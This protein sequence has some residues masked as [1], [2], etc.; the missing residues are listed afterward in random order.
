[1]LIKIWKKL[2]SYDGTKGTLFS[3]IATITTNTCID[4]LRAFNRRVMIREKTDIDTEGTG[5]VEPDFHI[6][7]ELLWLTDK[8]SSSQKDVVIMIYFRGHTQSEAARLLK[9]PLGTVK[10]RQRSAILALR[11]M[12]ENK[13][14]SSWQIQIT[15]KAK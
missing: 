10:T 2:P 5:L 3:W 12:C 6:R 8:L 15:E 13:K 9:L 4:Y 7:G 1:V 14:G 11:K